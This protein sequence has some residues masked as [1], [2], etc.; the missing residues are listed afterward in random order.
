MCRGEEESPWLREEPSMASAE[1]SRAM[2]A[3]YNRE[4]EHHMTS[5]HIVEYTRV[6]WVSDRPTRPT[7]SPPAPVW[8]G[9]RSQGIRGPCGRHRP[10]PSLCRACI[11]QSTRKRASVA[12]SRC[13]DYCGDVQRAAA[14]HGGEVAA[15]E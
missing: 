11:M 6:A 9:A 1:P 7:P 13:V 2:R 14:P 5:M 10:M 3:T 8:P 12:S 4:R 15:V